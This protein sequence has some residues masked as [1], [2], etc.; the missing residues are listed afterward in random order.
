MLQMILASGNITE[1][2]VRTG[3]VDADC[4]STTVMVMVNMLFSLTK[5]HTPSYMSQEEKTIVTQSFITDHIGYLRFAGLNIR[6][7]KYNCVFDF[8]Q[9]AIVSTLQF[10][11][12]DFNFV[13]DVSI[14]CCSCK[15]VNTIQRQTWDCLLVTEA[16]VEDSLDNIMADKFGPT[17]QNKVCPECLTN[18]LHY[19]SLSLMN[20]PKHLFVR[21]HPTTTTGHMKHK[22]S[23]HIDFAKIVSN[24]VIFTRSYT[25][26]TLQSF[27]TFDGIDDNGHYVTYARKKDD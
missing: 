20:C 14:E 21:F 16:T 11:D 7:G 10:Y 9:P 3:H 19:S 18:G 27:I 2:I 23:S 1:A 13:I 5:K 8:F 6:V 24:N 22:L 25:R 26:Y 4:V 12:I 17:L 15:K